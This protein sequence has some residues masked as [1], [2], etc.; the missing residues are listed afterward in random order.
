MERPSGLGGHWRLYVA[1]GV[2]SLLGGLFALMNPYAASVVVLQIVA[3]LFIFL[4]VMQVA[5][6]LRT[7]HGLSWFDLGMGVLQIL[8]GVML[9]TNVLG[10]LVSLTL[11]LAFL[12]LL[13]GVIL[14]MAGTNL[15]PFRPWLWLVVGGTISILLAVFVLMNLPEAA[16][17]LLGLLLGIDLMS[18]G[19]WLVAAGVMLREYRD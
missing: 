8:L 13:E 3:F 5:F 19:L 14:V 7:P 4:G 17:T 1:M 16:A 9:V 15:R 2:L 11:I 18:N 6:T 12:F 10:G